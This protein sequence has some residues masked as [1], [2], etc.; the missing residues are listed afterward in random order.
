MGIPHNFFSQSDSKSSHNWEN[1]PFLEALELSSVLQDSLQQE[2]GKEQSRSPNPWTI[3]YQD[4][5]SLGLGQNF[6]I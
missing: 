3:A 6:K 1:S 2:R 5:N 4:K